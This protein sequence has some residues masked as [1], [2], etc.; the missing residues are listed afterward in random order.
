MLDN[1]VAQLQSYRGIWRQQKF[2]ELIDQQV[3]IPSI[4][5]SRMDA[6][7]IL[8]QRIADLRTLFMPGIEAYAADN[9]RK[10]PVRKCPAQTATDTDLP[11]ALQHGP[12]RHFSSSSLVIACRWL[13][14]KPELPLHHLLFRKTFVVELSQ[15][16]FILTAGR[17]HRDTGEQRPYLRQRTLKTDLR[18]MQRSPG[19]FELARRKLIAVSN[20]R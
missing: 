7:K 14:E 3:E 2:I 13:F 1:L 20:I 6:R 5:R 11:Q 9:Q 10:H 16:G 18:A 12:V 17:I 19:V 4:R 15:P 8:T